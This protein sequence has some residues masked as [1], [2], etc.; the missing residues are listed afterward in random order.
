MINDWY[1]TNDLDDVIGRVDNDVP[2]GKQKCMGS[3]ILRYD[4]SA[5]S[6]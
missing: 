2:Q 4:K 5:D 3:F 1:R 6:S